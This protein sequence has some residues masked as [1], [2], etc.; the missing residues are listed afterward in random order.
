LNT[1]KITI[2]LKNLYVNVIKY[3]RKKIVNERIIEF[4]SECYKIN[5]NMSCWLPERFDDLIHRVDVLYHDE[6]GKPSSQDFIY[7]WEE[8]NVI[9]GC[10]LPDGD[11]FNS[12]IKPGYEYIVKCLI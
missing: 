11:S 8:N 5:K 7:I 12:S 9:I 3:I 4:L 10:I 6:R 1:E 2:E